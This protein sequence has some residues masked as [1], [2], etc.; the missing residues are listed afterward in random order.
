MT[1]TKYKEGGKL[2]LALEGISDT[3]TA[4]ELER[5]I[6]EETNG[7]TDLR[8]G[9][10]KI[11]FIF[12]VGLHVLVSAQKRMNKH[13]SDDVIGFLDMVGLTYSLSIE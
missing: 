7:L 8:I 12:S 11:L 6:T 10:N 2:T 5:V 1:I 4:P 3:N 13:Y 9:F